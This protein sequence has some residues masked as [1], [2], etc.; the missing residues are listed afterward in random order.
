LLRFSGPAVL[1]HGRAGHRHSYQGD[2][3]AGKGQ[4]VRHTTVDVIVDTRRVALEN[5]NRKVEDQ[6]GKAKRG[7][8]SGHRDRHLHLA[9]RLSG[10]SVLA[11]CTCSSPSVRLL[12]V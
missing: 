2:D 9:E 7:N 3:H 10:P 12:P 8:S 6:P 11:R 5:R 1:A 4:Q